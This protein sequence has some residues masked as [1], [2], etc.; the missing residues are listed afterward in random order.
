MMS[1]KSSNKQKKARKIDLIP[2]QEEDEP[3][4]EIPGEEMHS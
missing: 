1:K 3:K 2:I 4:P